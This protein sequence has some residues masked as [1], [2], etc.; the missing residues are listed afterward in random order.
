[1]ISVL[2]TSSNV[3]ATD[4]NIS[5]RVV[6]GTDSVEGDWPS[7]VYITAGDYQCGGTLIDERTILTAA[8]CL[9][10][11]A[12]QTNANRISVVVNAYDLSA[13]GSELSIKR[14]YIHDNYDPSNSASSNDIAL[15]RL[16]SSLT[17]TDAVKRSSK[18]TTNSAV[19]NEN[20]VTIIGWGSTVGYAPNEEVTASYPNILQEVEL[21]LQTDSDCSQN[22]G[23]S[24]DASTMI[25]AGDVN[26]GEDACQGD[27]GGPLMLNNG[28]VWEQLGVVSW[29]AGC[30]SAGNPGVYV[31]L[32]VY[33]DWIENFLTGI[34]VHNKLTFGL[35]SV[36]ES[37]QRY[38]LISNNAETQASL[39]F[40]LTGS[41]EFTFDANICESIAADSVCT[42]PITYTPI[43]TDEGSAS[44][45]IKSDIVGANDIT[46]ELTGNQS[47]SLGSSGGGSF[48]F[49]LT[50]PLLWLRRYFSSLSRS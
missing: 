17:N 27:S 4:N 20:D 35:N 21:P 23:A 1:M 43:T 50:L 19:A 37:E 41:S 45:T 6:G 42:L 11:G 14:T 13:I 3:T 18:T 34:A 47:Y 29:G 7:M 22:L 30:A 28:G 26:G 24:Y 8:H 44:L 9:Y 12:Y 48:F 33:E 32:A 39:T 5:T 2:L 38:L 40:S 36:G 31:R 46:T 49:I 15:L 10:D 16:S 25:C